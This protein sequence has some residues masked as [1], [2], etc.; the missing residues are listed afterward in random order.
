MGVHITF[1]RSVV[2]DS[3][4]LEQL[5]TMKV[6]GNYAAA[7]WFRVHGPGTPFKDAKAK[8]ASKAAVSY[9]DRLRVLVDDD[10]RRFPNGIVVESQQTTPPLQQTIKEIP[11]QR[12]QQP[13]PLQLLH[14]QQQPVV[15]DFFSDWG[16]SDPSIPTP[17]SAVATAPALAPASAAQPTAFQDLQSP[18]QQP[19]IQQQPQPVT[20]SL[21]QTQTQTQSAPATTTITNIPNTTTTAAF[22]VSSTKSAFGAKKLGAKKATRAINFDEA[23]RRAKEE[24]ARRELEEAEVKRLELEMKSVEPIQGASSQSGAFSSRLMFVDASAAVA[25]GSTGIGGFEATGLNDD[26][27][28]DRLNSG[29]GRLGFGFDPSSAQFG[30]KSG[31]SSTSEVG[32]PKFG[33]F[34]ST[35]PKSQQ[36]EEQSDAAKRFGNAK[37]ISSDQYFG[38]GNYD[39]AASAEAR[40][41]LQQ[42][43][44]K[45]GFGSQDYYGNSE[46]TG[47]G[48]SSY[49]RNMGS[50][51]P[52]G[53]VSPSLNM[54]DLMENVGN[55]L[56]V[57][58]NNF[59]DQGIEDI[60]NVRKIVVTGSSKLNDMLSEMQNRYGN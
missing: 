1:V 33:R 49:S 39:E 14:Q 11:Q 9:R 25:T 51:G 42:F 29:I 57:F 3:W 44:G 60:N 34:G 59:V 38:R 40:E 22:S 36:Q 32:A 56:R 20:P 8:Y 24:E 16:T 37:A 5:R 52:A 48:S 45:S 6:G 15:D 46:N 27:G 55:G 26:S 7:E 4:T 54:G 53:S 10:V 50:S 43:Q 19:V 31:S 12:P 17:T 21:P 23:E 47:T 41:R 28:V 13:Q 58:A 35:A 2:L 18:S 30:V